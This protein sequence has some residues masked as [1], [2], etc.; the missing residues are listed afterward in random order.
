MKVPQN[1]QHMLTRNNNRFLNKNLNGEIFT[2]DLYNVSSRQSPKDL[3]YLR[4]K[5]N[6]VETTED[7]KGLVRVTKRQR[8]RIVK[9]KEKKSSSKGVEVVFTRK[10]DSLR[11]PGSCCHFVAIKARRL[12]KARQRALKFAENQ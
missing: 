4:K 6:R 11:N 1:L 12:N 3:G 7:N 9:R 5:S 10:P 2:S 8:G